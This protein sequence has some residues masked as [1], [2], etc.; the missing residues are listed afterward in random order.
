MCY[1]RRLGQAVLE[2][3][4]DGTA[5]GGMG[6]VA[7]RGRLRMSGQR[8]GSSLSRGGAAGVWRGVEALGV[9]EWALLALLA[10]AVARLG[11]AVVTPMGPVGGWQPAAA[12]PVQAQAGAGAGFDP[13]FRS[14]GV[15][16]AAALSS[17]DLVLMGTRVDQASGRGSAI[18]ALPDEMQLS[19]AVGEEILPG[20]RLVAVG[21]DVV[22][23]DNGGTREQ[24]FL[25]QSA[26]AGGG[27][28]TALP[29]TLVPPPA[30]GREV[31]SM[32]PRLAADLQVMPRMEGTVIT[33]LVLTPRGSGMAF[34]A[35][36]LQ[37]GD[38]LVSVDGTGITALMTTLGDPAAL[39]RRLDAGGVRLG[40]ERGGQAVNVTLGAGG[41]SAGGVRM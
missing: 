40:L 39:V 8:S 14:A 21:F 20:V 34:A 5:Q 28:A 13:F 24:L 2:L 22:T 26:P 29:A 16:G 10:L 9:A 18:I 3:R 30:A 6:Q 1:P 23:I 27:A 38:V 32:A 12:A 15:A 36:G 17:L 37:P 7:M 11:W 19:F 33:G 35:A 4:V 31:V 25:D 41:Q